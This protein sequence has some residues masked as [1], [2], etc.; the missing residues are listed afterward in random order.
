MPQAFLSVNSRV[1]EFSGGKRLQSK[2]LRA[3]D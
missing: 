3:A 1:R 2:A